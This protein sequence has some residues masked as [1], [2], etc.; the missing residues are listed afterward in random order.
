MAKE[1]IL[2]MATN[3]WGLNKKNSVGPVSEWI[4]EVSP[5]N[6]KQWENKYYKLLERRIL[7]KKNLHFLSGKEYLEDIGRKLF[8]KITEVIKSEVEEVTEEDCIEYIKKLVINRTFEGYETEKETVYDHLEKL[9]NI[10][11]KPAQDK[12]D[13][14]YNVDFYIEINNKYI[15]LQIKPISYNQ[16]PQIHNWLEWLSKSHEKFSQKYGGKVFLVFSFKDNSGKRQIH[17]EEDLIKQIRA[18]IERLQQI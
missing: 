5:K 3:R 10:K 15:G 12:W 7:S 18:E 4:R 1:W 17:N 6:V 8:V 14:I 13:R 16:I 11:I 9:L 2:N